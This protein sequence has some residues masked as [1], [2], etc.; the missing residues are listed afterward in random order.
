MSGQ[1]KEEQLHDNG[2]KKDEENAQKQNEVPNESNEDPQINDN[3]AG[4]DGVAPEITEIELPPQTPTVL[5]R[6]DWPE[7]WEDDFRAAFGDDKTDKLLKVLNAPT[8]PHA[9][10]EKFKQMIAK[11]KANLACFQQDPV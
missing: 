3:D 4:G 5:E 7:T 9:E 8:G 11:I 2:E 10:S 6:L 1:K